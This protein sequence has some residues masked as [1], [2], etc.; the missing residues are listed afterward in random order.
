MIEVDLDEAS[1]F[2][3]APLTT[4]TTTF[5]HQ[6]A[7]VRPSAEFQRAILLVERIIFDVDRAIGFVDDRRIPFDR[8]VPK[9]RREE[10][11]EVEGETKSGGF[12]TCARVIVFTSYVPSALL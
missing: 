12:T 6:I 9:L 2:H 5:S 1:I 11:K 4:T 3:C 8:S 10:R 7:V